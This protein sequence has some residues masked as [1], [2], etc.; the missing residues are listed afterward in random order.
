MNGL[1]LSQEA[2]FL[3][4][5]FGFSIDGRQLNAGYPLPFVKQALCSA[6]DLPERENR[7]L[8]LDG[9]NNPGFSGG[10][11]VYLDVNT[12]K[13]TI[14]GVISG[15]HNQPDIVLKNGQPTE[16]TVQSN[17]GIIVA[18]DIDTIIKAIKTDRET[19]T[20]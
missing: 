9:H 16:Y 8:F 12:K 5:P 2:Y 15:Y 10:P 20:R 14:A 7:R 13:L 1:F 11:V 3:G 4:Y 17:S 6:F 18:Y 19:K